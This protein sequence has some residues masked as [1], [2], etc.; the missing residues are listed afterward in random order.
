MQTAKIVHDPADV[1]TRLAELGLKEELLLEALRQANLYRVRTTNHHPRLYRYQVM[2]AETIAA[3][4]DLLVPEGWQKLDEGQYELT[5]NPSGTMAIAVA[6]GDDNVAQVERTP[7][8]K[9]PKGRHTIA[10]VESNRQ[11]DMFADLL[12]VKEVDTETPRDTWVLLHRVTKSGIHSELSRPTEISDDGMIALW[13]ERILLGK[14][15]LD[16]DP[17]Q[18]NPPDQP[19]IDIVIS[20]K[21]A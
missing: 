9:S 18:I 13:S 10:A 20:K 21:S 14:I 19:D 15:E 16:G 2:T 1:S 8:N 12:P 7:S 17:V 11:A 3:L 6:S 5:R 4:R